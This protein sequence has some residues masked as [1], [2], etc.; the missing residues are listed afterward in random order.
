MVV[1][2]ERAVALD[3]EKILTNLG[4]DVAPV[5]LKTE[6]AFKKMEEIS[7]D[8]ILLDTKLM[9]KREGQ[10]IFGSV[11]CLR[12]IPI[13]YLT[14]KAET[15]ALKR[16]EIM[17]PFS[18]IFMPC[19]AKEVSAA[20]EIALYRHKTE[21]ILNQKKEALESIYRMAMSANPTIEKVCDDA[22]LNL[23][24]ILRVAGVSIC[25]RRGENISII[26]LLHHGN[27]SHDLSVPLKNYP[28]ALVYEKKESCRFTGNL[29]EKFPENDLFSQGAFNSYLGVPI[30]GD[31]KNVWGV[32]SVMDEGERLF[33]EEEARLISIF[34]RYVTQV[35]ERHDFHR[36]LQTS[37]EKE[38]IFQI[39]TGVAHEV[40]NPLNS[41][42]AISEALSQDL[43][44]QPEY[45]PFLDH[46][47]TQVDRLSVL[48][49]D[50]LELG[51]PIKEGALSRVPISAICDSAVD[52][53]TK[54]NHRKRV[55]IN[56]INHLLDS[57]R[58][59]VK[60]DGLKLQ[61][62]LFNLIENAIHHSPEG[63]EILIEIPEVKDDQVR[64]L[65]VDMGQGI[66]PQYLA[67]VFEP[68]FSL[69]KGGTG[70]GLSIVKHIVKSFGG[71]V[72]INNNTPYPGVTVEITLPLA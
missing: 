33:N 2:E 18:C 41:I 69:R 64:V 49:K 23:R 68:F 24:D 27:L 53:W 57:A 45:K 46:I 61:Q 8:L 11:R 37:Q 55:K 36:Q 39:A 16:A 72:V 3:M 38:L 62:V 13:L 58:T 1:E 28:S 63:T 19:E 20:I 32:I 56:R 9:D 52:L 54:G 15:E 51:K 67:R 7:P 70:L 48:M 5:Q 47:S 17:T 22:A 4:Y 10:E 29:G 12:S 40:R 65:V 31:G 60:A 35:I 59:E 66:P 44:D 14:A 71:E 34:T 26:S 25:H 6:E 42:L 21:E 43:K 50:L 30:K